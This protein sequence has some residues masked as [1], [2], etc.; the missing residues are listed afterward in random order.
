MCS[1]DVDACWMRR[2]RQL[3]PG[4]HPSQ[5]SIMRGPLDLRPGA[6][7]FRSGYPSAGAHL[8]LFTGR[9][10]EAVECLCAQGRDE[11]RPLD[12][13][14]LNHYRTQQRGEAAGHPDAGDNIL[15]EVRLEDFRIIAQAAFP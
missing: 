1:D 9:D 7:G 6:M 8:R 3:R 10:S 13:R 12:A 14:R 5:T 4:V 2:I 15:Q 11:Y